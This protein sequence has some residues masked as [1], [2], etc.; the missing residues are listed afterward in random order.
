MLH[1]QDIKND[2]TYAFPLAIA[3]AITTFI[4]PFN[5]ALAQDTKTVLVP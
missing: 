5:T 4:Y 2:K 3:G 1:I